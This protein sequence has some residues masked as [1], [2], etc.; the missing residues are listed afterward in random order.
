MTHSFAFGLA[1]LLALVPA[2]ILPLR[3][4]GARPGPLFW[5]LL[6]TAVAGPA[7]FA[8]AQLHRNWG[9]GLSMALWVSIAAST[10]IF[11]VTVALAREAWRLAAL[12]LPYLCLLA[13]VALIWSHAPAHH[14]ARVRLD[15]WLVV[16]IAVSITT[17]ALATLAAVAGVA[18]FLKERALK[19]KQPGPL[20]RRLP[21]VA[22]AELLELR[23]LVLA[24]VV[25][26]I[27]IL[28]GIA[29]GYLSEGP[30]LAFD[31]KTV[32]S[33]LAFVLIGG[34]LALRYATGLRG[35]RAARLVLV[36]YL[37]LTLAY[38]GVK[39]VT[40]VLMA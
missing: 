38:P 7:A 1:A 5:L 39:F 16:H 33:L 4:D 31:H 2:S 8:L 35:R 17:Y 28:T 12:L 27:G 15:P 3:R 34:L 14:P 24:E 13:L 11:A 20:S 19:R 32:L 37:L 26:A 36:A 10:L 22:F 9:T 29:L 40:D 21:S 23:L 25:L 30:I 6:A 18:V